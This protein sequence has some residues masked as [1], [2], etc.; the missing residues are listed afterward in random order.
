VFPNLQ[1]S[2]HNLQTGGW[3]GV[4]A[5]DWSNPS[6][7]YHFKMLSDVKSADFTPEAMSGEGVR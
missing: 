5:T 1:W 2:T 3:S 4:G 6:Y 7:T